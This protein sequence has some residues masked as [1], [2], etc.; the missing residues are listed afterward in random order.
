MTTRTLISLLFG[1][2]VLNSVCSVASL[3]PQNGE[4]QITRLQLSPII[5]PEMDR[6]LSNNIQGP[7]LIRVPEWVENPLGKY[8]LYFADHKGHYIRLAYA[9]QL[10]GPWSIHAPGTLQ[11]NQTSFPQEPL[12]ISWPKLMLIKAVA[13]WRGIDL[14]KLP[15]DVIKELSTPHIASPDVHVDNENKRIVMYFHGLKSAG[16]QVT[17]VATSSDGIAFTAHNK[18]LAKTYLRAFEHKGQT[19]ALTMPGLFYRSQDGMSNFEEGPL[20]FNK[21][22]RHAGLLKR[23]N[24]LFVFWTQV[25][26]IPERILL[27]KIDISKPWMQ[28]TASEPVEVLRP[29]LD[30]E[31]ANAPLQASVRSV[32]YGHVNQLRDPF[33]FEE[34]GKIY[35]L[36][37]VAGESGI[38][39]SEIDPTTL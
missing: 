24:T 8:Y 9:D 20:L 30:W 13:K 36:Y 32:A 21:D 17:R 18:N 34:A 38:A 26:H 22:M 27:S 29:E 25:G 5:F 16:Q 35:L 28:W 14:D 3:P 11:L 37:V 31:G 7:S 1:A 4:L 23:G 12:T 6:S 10:T 19:Y 2:L 33:I 39:I 15:H